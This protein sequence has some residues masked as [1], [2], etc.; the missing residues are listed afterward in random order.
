MFFN[1]LKK[2]RGIWQSSELRVLRLFCCNYVFACASIWENTFQLWR[3]S[4]IFGLGKY[5]YILASIDFVETKSDYVSVPY[6]IPHKSNQKKYN[7]P[8]IVKSNK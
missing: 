5:G 1:N 3:I 4:G 7:D 2:L 8:V 6:S